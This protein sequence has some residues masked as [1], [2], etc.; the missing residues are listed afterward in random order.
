MS[1]VAI[2]QERDKVPSNLTKTLVG[3]MGDMEL[4]MAIMLG[5]LAAPVKN[6]VRHPC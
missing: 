4:K 5:G 2:C 1:G 6:R 3:A